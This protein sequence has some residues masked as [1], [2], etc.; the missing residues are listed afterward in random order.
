MA[1]DRYDSTKIEKDKFGKRRYKTTIYPRIP[2][3]KED[4]YII[5]KDGDRCDTL[6]YRYYDNTDFWWI[7]AQANHIGK[8][9][10][11]IPA[12]RQIRVPT[13][14]S[15]IFSELEELNK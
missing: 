13:D 11:R 8:G 2:K 4:I 9:T 6:A 14:L 3:S 10:L 12:G 15:D 5:S 7:I 1:D